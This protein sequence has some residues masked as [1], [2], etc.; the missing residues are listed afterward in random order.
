M[1]EEREPVLFGIHVASARGRFLVADGFVMLALH[2]GDAML[3]Q[4]LHAAVGM[5]SEADRVAEAMDGVRA[6]QAGIAHR[7]LERDP[8]PVDLPEERRA[9]RGLLSSCCSAV[10]RTRR[11]G[12][13]P[14]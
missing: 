7:R 5:R 4:E 13:Y 6:A 2:G 1:V 9:H 12:R 10:L 14:S 8:V 3:A 11:S